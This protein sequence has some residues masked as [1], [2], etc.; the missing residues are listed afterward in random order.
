M[1][2]IIGLAKFLFVLWILALAVI[3]IAWLCVK[4]GHALAND[5]RATSKLGKRAGFVLLSVLLAGWTADIV[6]AIFG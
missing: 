1:S 4:T 3:G 2:T 5:W 6:G